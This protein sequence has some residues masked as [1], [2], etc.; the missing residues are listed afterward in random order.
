MK[1]NDLAQM[2]FLLIILHKKV[3]KDPERNKKPCFRTLHG[4]WVSL[5]TVILR[6]TQFGGFPD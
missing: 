5:L 3:E 4:V 1:L 2:L 6:T